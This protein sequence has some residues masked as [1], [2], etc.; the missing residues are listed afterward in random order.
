MPAKL[1]SFAL[2]NLRTAQVQASCV[3]PLLTQSII[4][5]P[6]TTAS[7]TP[8]SLTATRDLQVISPF[9]SLTTR[10]GARYSEIPRIY[11]NDDSHRFLGPNFFVNRR[12]TSQQD[13]RISPQSPQYLHSFFTFFS[14]PSYIDNDG[15]QSP[16]ASIPRG[17]VLTIDTLARLR[18][19]PRALSTFSLF[20]AY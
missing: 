20:T 4:L 10:K 18:I 16:S 3:R 6:N 11:A 17:S 5:Q 8:G 2:L 14:L 13:H 12:I 19:R 9:S 15:L 7:S 1:F